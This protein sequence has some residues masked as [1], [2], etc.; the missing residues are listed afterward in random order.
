LQ[1]TKIDDRIMQKFHY[2]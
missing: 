2:W 1:T